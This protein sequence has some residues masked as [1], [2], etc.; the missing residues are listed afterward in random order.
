[1]RQLSLIMTSPGFFT[2]VGQYVHRTALGALRVAVV[3]FKL[4]V[5]YSI[6][7]YAGGQSHYANEHVMSDAAPSAN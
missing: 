3:K 6:H 5:P 7:G 2:L 4:Y 1:M